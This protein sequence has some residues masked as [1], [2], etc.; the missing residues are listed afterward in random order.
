[1]TTPT[2]DEIL[3]A[4]VEL[5]REVEDLPRRLIMAGDQIIVVGGL[6]DISENLGLMSAGEL[7]IGEGVP[8]KGD[9]FTGLR[10]AYPALSY[11]N[12]DWHLAGL[13]ADALQVGIRATDGKLL[14]G[15]GA[16]ILDETGITA[17]AGVIGG[18]TIGTDTL[19]AGTTNI[20]L[21]SSNK[22]ISIND[23]TFGN[24][25][26]QLEY[27][28]G[29]PRLYVGDGANAYLQFDG[30]KLT[31]KAANTE[32]DSSG[33]LT[34]SSATIS[35]T[36]TASAGAIG[37]WDINAT[38]IEKLSSD[39]GIIL[40]S[41]TPSI[42]VGDTSSTHIVIDG[43]NKY[44]QSSNFSAGASGFRIEADTGNAE[45]NYI[46]ARGAVRTAVFIKDHI[47][48]VSGN[49]LVLDSDVLAVD[50]TAA[51]NSTLTIEGNTTFAVGDILR[52]KDDTDDEWLEVT[53]VTN[54][55]TY[56]VTRD[57][58]GS[59]AA[60]S[61]PAWKRGATVVNYT[62]SGGGGV[63][64]IS[65]TNPSLS[66]FTHAG[67][68]WSEITEHVRL[69][70]TISK[71]GADVSSAATTAL[72]IIHSAQTYNSES[73]GAGDLLIGDNSTNKANIL[74]DAS[75]GKLLFRGATAAQLE[76]SAG[77]RL[78]G[79]LDAIYGQA[80]TWI[81]K[82]GLRL[83][84]GWGTV[85]AQI[86]Y[87]TSAQTAYNRTGFHA[88]SGT[89]FNIL[90]TC[91][92]Y[93]NIV[94]FYAF[95]LDGGAEITSITG[96]R[97]NPLTRVRRDAI[98]GG[99]CTE[100]WY[101]VVGDFTTPSQWNITVTLNQAANV[102]Y[103]YQP[104]H[105][106]DQTTPVLDHSGGTATSATSISY[107]HTTSENGHHGFSVAGTDTPGKKIRY[108]TLNRT[109]DSNYP[110]NSVLST[111]L[112]LDE[113]LSSNPTVTFLTS[114]SSAV[115][116][117]SS[118][119]TPN[120]IP[121]PLNLTI[122]AGRSALRISNNHAIV[123]GHA[124]MDAARIWGN[125]GNDGSGH[126]AIDVFMADNVSTSGGAVSPAN[127]TFTITTHGLDGSPTLKLYGYDSNYPTLLQFKNSVGRTHL[128]ITEGEVIVN[129]DGLNGGFRVAGSADIGDHLFQVTTSRVNIGD[130]TAGTIAAFSIAGIVFNEN[131]LDRDFRVEGDTEPNLLFVDAGN[132][133]IGIK[134]A[135]PGS[136]MDVDG[137]IFANTPISTSD[138]RSV[139]NREYVDLA[140]TSLGAS[141]YLYDEDDATGY[142]ICYLDPSGD[143][144]ACIEVAN[145][146]DND[147]IA[148]WIS[149]PS[150]T[151]D[152]LLKGIFSFYVTMSKLAG[153]KT[154]RVYWKLFERKLDTS[155]VEIATSAA[156]NEITS[157]AAY[158]I[159]LQLDSDYIL[160]TGSRIVGKLYADVSGSGN[161]PTIRI[162]YQGNT[163]SR[164]EIPANSEIFK[165]IF[166]PYSGAVQDVDLGAHS[167]TAAGLTLTGN[168][169]MPD[170]GTI[171]QAAGPLLTFDDTNDYLEITGCSVGIGTATPGAD[172]EVNGTIAAP[173]V[174]FGVA[175]HHYKL[176]CRFDTSTTDFFGTTPST[177]TGGIIFP[178]H[179][180]PQVGAGAVQLAEAT[181]NYCTNPSAETNT[182]GWSATR[183]AFER[184]SDRAYIGSYSF[185]LT[186]DN[187]GNTDAFIAM[188]PS[189][190]SAGGYITAQARIWIPSV[191]TPPHGRGLKIVIFDY[192]GSTYEEIGSPQCQTAG[193][194]V[195]LTVTK[196]IRADATQVFVRLYLGDDDP[197]KY[198][199]WDAIQFE[200]K[201]YP[202]PYCDGSLG[203]GHS[204]SG[205]P[206]A[207][208]SSRTATELEYNADTA[209]I[210]E[211]EGSFAAWVMLPY[212][213]GDPG[214]ND[215]IFAWWDAWNTE[216][217][218]LNITTTGLLSFSSFAGSVSQGSIYHDITDWQPFEWHHVV[219]IWKENDRRLYVDGVLEGTD[220]DWTPPSIAD[221]QF[222]LGADTDGGNHAN[223]WID[224]V[225]VL[226]RALTDEEAYAL[227]KSGVPMYAG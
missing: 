88:A 26:I 149:A 150:Q 111:G 52:I 174:P 158:I 66:V 95:V 187:N 82:T 162:C 46:T 128:T 81:D 201:Q 116:W 219:C 13:N 127:S 30:T 68:P 14:A 21:D 151:P 107:I 73:L 145:L 18:W 196:Q 119:I 227:Y 210:S 181:T 126:L 212:T 139:V 205:T 180:T 218:Y 78:K 50:M 17:T 177:A 188:Y 200:Y 98:A 109:V 197:T 59:Y 60:N 100:I 24:K 80:E 106:V 5:Q 202:T 115:D 137:I 34:A 167:L 156:S 125:V 129:E 203:D 170:G 194:W 56:T 54:A 8:G 3:Q 42:Q 173:G 223:L 90:T 131:G 195:F 91:P 176:L 79:G 178:T 35:G 84:K 99:I 172:L 214:D 134:T 71:F 207:S 215:M 23:G 69:E 64:L 40:N 226:D 9:G 108:G 41:A 85:R 121:N 92:T 160:D 175:A 222:V 161:A 122:H 220:T 189:G 193:E 28:S 221:T 1:M 165:N 25:G 15:G 123:W 204:W 4:V 138:L 33:N 146:D 104:Y 130:S 102:V 182:S 132:D 32:L 87:H 110:D 89:S 168:I 209:G 65:G 103:Y 76:L 112:N 105:S 29:T 49:F 6:S 117:A 74:W 83:F 186:G 153:N 97:D 171:G 101:D 148:G 191:W 179:I 31:W 63:R 198:C 190:W 20:V 22:S 10:I 12:E 143:A 44:I 152:K 94:I 57:K 164:W 140:V 120:P 157:P 86:P 7:R 48:A 47:S 96:Y 208:T 39:I 155:E 225:V 133:R 159:P 93:E 192:N 72:A 67:S 75:E 184:S 36:I 147:Y 136:D 216:S 19:T 118:T 70:E 183:V 185:K 43:A 55:P 62:Q 224:D 53:D 213:P 166:V 45:F 124:W 154:L 169:T 2:P 38:A 211:T 114:D 61:N 16:V 58:A 142:K 77:G 217:L 27:N 135:T 113:E 163:L 51:D 11:N 144:E 206:H 37:G 199:Y 141:F